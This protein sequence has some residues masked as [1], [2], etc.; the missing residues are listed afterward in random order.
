MVEKGELGS[1]V[2]LAGDAMR[3]IIAHAAITR[4]DEEY[5]AKTSTRS[6]VPRGSARP[7]MPDR[8]TFMFRQAYSRSPR[9]PQASRAGWAGTRAVR[10]G[11]AAGRKYQWFTR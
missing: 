4:D 6:G 8:A 2:G 3:R 5:G 11:F 9:Y 7:V 10:T 1:G